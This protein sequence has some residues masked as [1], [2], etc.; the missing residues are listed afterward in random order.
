MKPIE[1]RVI[2]IQ[3]RAVP[4]SILRRPRQKHIHIRVAIEGRLRVSAP[5]RCPG[6]S[7]DAALMRKSAWI[8]KQ[9]TRMHG[10][11]EFL[12]PELWVLYAGQRL[13]IENVSGT[14]GKVDI[15]PER[16]ICRVVS[17]PEDVAALIRRK[18]RAEAQSV[19]P[20]MTAELASDVDI[21]IRHVYVRDQRTRWG[22]SSSLGNISLNWRLIMAPNEVRDYLMYHELAHQLHMNHSERFWKLVRDWC[23]DYRIHD[24][25][26][27]NHSYLLALFR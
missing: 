16:G 26:L 1:E 10:F 13:K 18:L 5:L 14:H 8:M 11:R 27:A 17:N 22:A 9:L 15:E 7:I 3:N 6:G 12:D 20:S 23:P 19:L 21:Q 2:Y 4:V 25:W 24:K